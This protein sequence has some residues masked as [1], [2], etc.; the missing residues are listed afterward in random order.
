MKRTTVLLTLPIL[1]LVL[2]LP[3]RSRADGNIGP[4]KK[5]EAAVGAL[6]PF[7]E[8]EIKDKD[9]PALSIALVDDQDIVWAS[10][11]G[12]ANPKEKTPATAETVYRVGSVSKLFTDIAVMQLVE[13]GKLDLDAPVTKYL[14][15]FKPK[16]PFKKPI[17]LRHMMAHRSG[18]VREPPVGHYFDPTGPALADTVKSLNTTELVYAPE[19]KTKYSNAAIAVVGYVLEHTQK[20]PFEKYLK[21]AV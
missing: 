7:I 11:F 20:Q 15:D 9:L 5:Y 6:K 21:Q 13:Q 19:S 4:A 12:F 14:P 17:A 2:A 18:L 1:A 10:G 16:D 3:G 8:R